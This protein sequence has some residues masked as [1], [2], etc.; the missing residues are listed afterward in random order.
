[1]PLNGREGYVP[2]LHMR[3]D[4]VDRDIF[5][6]LVDPAAG[7]IDASLQSVDARPRSLD[8]RR[9]PRF[10]RVAIGQSVGR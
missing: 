3:N 1:M 10:F 8:D 6:G 9:Q 2:H 4:P 5:C 7:R